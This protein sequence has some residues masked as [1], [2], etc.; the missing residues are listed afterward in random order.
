M[1]AIRECG[2]TELLKVRSRRREVSAGWRGWRLGL[3]PIKQSQALGGCLLSRMA[4]VAIVAQQVNLG[5]LARSSRLE[6][7]LIAA[8]RALR[9]EIEQHRG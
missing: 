3:S 6:T 1:D 5:A 9:K 4:K 2:K 7:N 8:L